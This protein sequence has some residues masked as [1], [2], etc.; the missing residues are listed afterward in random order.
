MGSWQTRRFAFSRPQNG[1]ASSP[2]VD[3]TFKTKYRNDPVA[4]ARECITWKPGKGPAP[5]QEEIMQALVG[6]KRASARGPHGLGKTAMAA[7]IVWWFALT[8]D[9]EDWKVVTTASAWR[10]LSKFLWPEIH[11]WSRRIRWDVVGREAPQRRQ[12][13]LDLSIKLSTGEAFAVASDTPE[14]I[15]GAHADC[16][17]YLFDEAKV[18]P[19]GTF[20]AA[21]GAFSGAGGDTPNEAYAL[22]IST[23]GEPQ[24][25]FYEIQ[26][27]KPG[28]EDW[29]VRAVT[30]QETID[31]GR[32]SVE[33]AEQRKK[34]W[35]EGSAV[36]LN[37][38]EGVFA[39]SD[40]EGIIPLSW[41]EA[42]IERWHAWVEAERPGKLKAVGVDV[43][44]T[45]ED[46][47]VLAPR[48]GDNAIGEL[49]YYTKEDPME[50][51]GH[52]A[53]LLGT[54]RGAY[55][56][57]DVIGMGAGVVTRLA[58]QGYEVVAFNAASGSKRKDR[59]GELGF[60]NKRS[61]A[62]WNM[63]ELLD[64]TY[65]SDLCLPP[66]DMLIGDLTAPHYKVVSGGK[67]QVEAK[68]DIKKRLGR[69]TDPGDAVMQALHEE[70]E[71]AG[72]DAN[73]LQALVRSGRGR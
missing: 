27:R 7:W 60:V 25:R 50:T 2:P 18:I 71:D 73:T 49:R 62:W 36:Y 63:R 19:A 20:D 26:S 66:D 10:Q 1:V 31:A 22:A 8:R 55:A 17:L 68:V 70:Y 47:T 41:V 13:L 65:K 23:P 5:Y 9:G 72:I 12:E 53:G 44:W 29:W 21:E 38:V 16:L 30:L 35:G 3:S 51:T 46:K 14:L 40:E 4:F 33:W 15:E 43:A 39:S 67:I 64:P 34:Q 69:S 56:V 24:G 45:G 58:E 32:V 54:E 52:V 11:K 42:A 59:S 61:E 57:V 48:Y 37:R 6:R 28:Y